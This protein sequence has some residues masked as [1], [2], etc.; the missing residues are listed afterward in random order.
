MV[1]LSSCNPRMVRESFR[2]ARGDEVV[3]AT[4]LSAIKMESFY[5]TEL[6][7]IPSSYGYSSTSPDMFEY[8]MRGPTEAWRPATLL[9]TENWSDSTLL[10][11]IE[12]YSRIGETLELLKTWSRRYFSFMW[13][14]IES[15]SFERFG[16]LCSSIVDSGAAQLSSLSILS[17]GGTLS[18]TC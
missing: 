14:A 3:D 6:A 11:M 2:V 4:S 10:P 8:L 1:G 13:F 12:S 16:G 9:L 18:D 15:S 5:L 17:S 7:R